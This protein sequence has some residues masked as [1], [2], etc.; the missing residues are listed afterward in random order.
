VSVQPGLPPMTEHRVQIR[1]PTR[2]GAS[3]LSD[4][5]AYRELA[6]FLAKR[7]LQVRY[8]QSLLGVAWAVL[9]PL[10]LMGI[11]TL[12][13]SQLVGVNS[14]G[15]PYPVYVL[16]GISVWTFVSS[17][18][19]QCG[20][21][22]VT[23]SNLL[24]K[25]FFPRLIVPLGKVLALLVDLTI[26]IVLLLV[27]T[28]IF[29]GTPGVAVLT[30]PLWLLL[31]GAFALGAGLLAATLNVKYRDVTIIVPFILQVGLF[32]TPVA[33]PASLVA[34]TGWQTLYALNPASSAIVGM[35]WALFG[36]EAPR[37][38]SLLVS[39]GVT[40]V[41]GIAATIYFRRSEQHFADII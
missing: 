13:F 39:V 34:G 18:I 22:L 38:T 3:R 5:W 15:V 19:A 29:V 31:G 11:F 32:I 12:I 24:T 16:A 20:L 41:L 14:E 25:V 21:S 28:V 4:L 30:V 23:D 27:V 6:Y 1:P 9:Q 10:V 7:D 37:L 35:R 17:G 40:V 26:V 36:T 2:W 8:K 33:Y